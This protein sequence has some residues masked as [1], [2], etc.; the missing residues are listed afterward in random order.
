VP[1]AIPTPVSRDVVLEMSE[2]E[3]DAE[4][5]DRLVGQPLGATPLGEAK[6]QSVAVQ[7]R[8]RQVRL[9]GNALVGILR[10][11]FAL[12]GTVEPAGGR[13]IVN[14]RE[15]SVGGV[16]LPA[17]ARETLAASLQ[18]QVDSVLADR[19]VKIRTIEIDDG[20]IRMVGTPNP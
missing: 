2:S 7:L 20:T 11:P 5:G 18:L 15:A 12:T 17:P 6:I 9:N 8:D 14:V 19:A 16:A 10:T 4:L 13:P 3:L 1:T